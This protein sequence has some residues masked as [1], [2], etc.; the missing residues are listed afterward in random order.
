MHALIAYQLT[1]CS[2]T[3]A[4]FAATATATAAAALVTAAAAAA[5]AATA[6]I[7]KAHYFLSLSVSDLL[8][9]IFFCSCSSPYS[10]ASAVGGQPGT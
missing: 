10:S 8:P 7:S 3:T 4:S 6:T 9:L 1:Q 5:A 2:A